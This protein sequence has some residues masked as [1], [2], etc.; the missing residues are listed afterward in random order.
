MKKTSVKIN[1]ETEHFIAVL[2]PRYQG[3]YSLVLPGVIKAIDL[4]EA[5]SDKQKEAFIVVHDGVTSGVTGEVMEAINKTKGSLRLYGRYI[6]MRKLPLDIE[7]H[8]KQSHYRWVDQIIEQKPDLFLLF[9]NGEW[10]QVA[11]ALRKAKEAGIPTHLV[12]IRL[13]K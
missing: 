11:Y 7:L 5:E 6:T 8:G 10:K 9:D 1:R 2:G 13:E 4:V 12:Q 3:N